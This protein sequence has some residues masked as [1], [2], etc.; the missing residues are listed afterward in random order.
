MKSP[1]TVE[2]DLTR[3][4]EIVTKYPEGSASSL[5][6]ALQDVQ[7]AYG[8]LPRPAV[9]RVAAA[10][11]V[12]LAQA[13]AVAKFYRAFSL[14]PQG[15]VVVKVCTGTACH[16]RGAQEVLAKLERVLAV[17]AG[18]TTPDGAFSLQT[19][20]CVGACAMAPLVLVGDEAKGNAKASA[21][22]DYLKGSAS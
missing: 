1:A 6:A 10:L 11:R 12:P 15:R 2:I 9:A 4:T 21:V 22:E 16:L 19:V 3:V 5:I 13:F 18:E 14:T 17:R 8:Y 7:R 20:Q